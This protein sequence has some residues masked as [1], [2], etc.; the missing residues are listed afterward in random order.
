MEY[1]TKLVFEKGL[2]EK[3]Q[4]TIVVAT[5][6]NGLGDNEIETKWMQLGMRYANELLEQFSIDNVD[7]I[8]DSGMTIIFSRQPFD[9]TNQLQEFSSASQSRMSIGFALKC[10]YGEDGNA[11]WNRIGGL[12]TPTA[13]LAHNVYQALVSARLKVKL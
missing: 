12:G 2:D 1:I 8:E 13:I 10:N 6:A 9:D 11:N 4:P 3:N 5:D 7:H